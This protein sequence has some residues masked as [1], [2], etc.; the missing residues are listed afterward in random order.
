MSKSCFMLVRMAHLTVCPH[1]DVGEAG[2][3]CSLWS[4]FPRQVFWILWW[5]N[6]E[7]QQWGS[8][9]QRANSNAAAQLNKLSLKTA[10]RALHNQE[11][12]GRFN[13]KCWVKILHFNTWTSKQVILKEKQQPKPKPHIWLPY[14]TRV[15]N[16]KGFFFCSFFK[17]A[18]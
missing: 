2:L 11:S 6:E 10:G 4:P 9:P 5:Q 17:A 8:K 15:Y 18:S 7:G 12:D 14:I 13:F 1:F 3:C 16:Y